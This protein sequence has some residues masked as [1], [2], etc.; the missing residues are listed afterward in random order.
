[1][2]KQNNKK[3]T[4][5]KTIEEMPDRELKE[6][7][8]DVMAFEIPNKIRPMPYMGGEELAIEYSYTDLQAKCPMTGLKDIYKIR[9]KFVPDKIIPELKSLKFYFFSYETLPISHEHLI[10]KIYKDFKKVI[11]PKKIAMILYVAERG[12]I[13]TT[14]ALGD[15]KL[16]EFG[17]PAREENFAR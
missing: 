8:K 7:I 9:I 5:A 12:E 16:L 2:T 13:I 3:W 15:K 6:R 10:A 11:K 4:Y 17:R 14:I 1:M